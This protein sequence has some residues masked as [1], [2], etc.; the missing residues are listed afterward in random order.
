MS[1]N[2][3][4]RAVYLGDFVILLHSLCMV[5]ATKWPRDWVWWTR[6]TWSGW[7]VLIR[8]EVYNVYQYPVLYI[9]TMEY[10]HCQLTAHTAINQYPFPTDKDIKCIYRIYRYNWIIKRNTVRFVFS[11]SNAA[12]IEMNSLIV[13]FFSF[14][15]NRGPRLLLKLIQ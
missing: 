9:N 4:Y 12:C 2:E 1:W 15:R 6:E 14:L 8:L 5:M 10:K 7:P 13:V 11:F 3:M